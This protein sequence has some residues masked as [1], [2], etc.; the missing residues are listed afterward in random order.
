MQIGATFPQ[1]EIGTDLSLL[2]DFVQGVE[3]LGYDHILDRKS[4][5]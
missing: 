2:R 3:A 1:T 4:V 5:V